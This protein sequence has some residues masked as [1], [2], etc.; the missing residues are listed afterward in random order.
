MNINVMDVLL[1]I[2]K[3][4]YKQSSDIEINKN[5]KIKTLKF[6]SISFIRIIVEIEERLNIQF[7]DD[8]LLIEKYEILGD[9]EKY[10][11]Q[12]LNDSRT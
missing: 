12:K 9:L 3:K 10:V 8:F 5:T 11:L 1:E 7:D 4:Y 6:D 2:I